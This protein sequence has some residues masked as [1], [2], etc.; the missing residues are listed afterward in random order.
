MRMIRRI[1]LAGVSLLALSG[2]A[3]AD[4]IS[5][6]F[7]LFA[8]PLGG[9]FSFGTLVTLSQIALYG[10]PVI[11]SVALGAL[12]Q[13]KIE[14]QKY[15]NTY[16]ND[17]NPSEVRAVGRVR[18]GGSKAF[19]NTNG[20]N[21][22]R[23][24]LHTKGPID[25]VE[26]H[27]LG[28]REVI[29]DPD[30]SVQS[31]PYARA[32]GSP[33][34]SFVYVNSKIGDGTETSWSALISAFSNLWDANHRVRG[35]AQSLLRYISP[36][37]DTNAEIK[38]FQQLYQNGAPEYQRVQRSELIYDPRLDST[39]GGSGSQRV[40]TSSTWAWTDNGVLCAT[41]VLRAF[42]GLTSSDI[43]WTLTAS[44]AD[45]ADATVATKTGTE[46]RSRCWGL[47]SSE[48]RR[49]DVMKDVLDS[50]GGEI[51]PTAEGKFYIRLIDDSRTSELDLTSRD[52]YSIDLKA[53]PDGVE[54]P[55][56]CR[57][58]Y[59]SP[60][61][62]YD[63]FEINLTGIGWARIDA[64]VTAYG[65]K[66]QDIDLPFC[67]SASQAQR[68]ARRMFTM[69]RADTGLAKLNMV[70]MAAWGLSVISMPLP[71]CNETVT[72]EIGP[73]RPDDE[74]GDVEIPFKVID[75]LT[76]WNPATDEADAPAQLPD[77]SA[78]SNLTTP[79][80]PTAIIQVHYIVS[81]GY[82]LRIAY[83]IPAGG[84][85]REVAYLTYT[86]GLPDAWHSMT[87]PTSTLAYDAG[88]FTGQKVSARTRIGDA[89]GNVSYWSDEFTEN[90][91]AI[92]NSK[93]AA[94]TIDTVS[95]VTDGQGTT[96]GYTAVARVSSI[97][98]VKIDGTGLSAADTRP[99]MT[100]QLSTTDTSFPITF[101]ATCYASDGTASDTTT[102]I[103]SG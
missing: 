18:V 30:G 62:N 1:L 63:M 84:T 6:G 68:I 32:D 51:V 34:R 61:R 11:A 91:L 36:G 71:D 4:P 38:K 85:T 2:A 94:P 90:S 31:P 44:E 89:D 15:K 12:N 93:P 33:T 92:D 45:R 20:I 47:W 81:G 16:E 19:G 52:I 88:D 97:N 86:G 25:A 17:A 7:L 64:E 27:Y 39:N 42:P 59:Y 28:G 14:P 70:G 43:D 13:P 26:S 57:L 56:V 98:T 73:V 58:K 103:Y 55:N 53:G 46:A 75:T 101:T 9:V 29:V 66:Y 41:H 95:V 100:H 3:H 48:Y 80:A 67:P 99:G 40:D 76:A 50:I 60:E 37:L 74:N 83:T 69:A 54:R 24:I 35:I 21:R 8:G 77:L 79:A 96:I 49:G 23:L 22:Y 82:E 10:L 5:L 65:E 72:C 78:P 102:L 87:E